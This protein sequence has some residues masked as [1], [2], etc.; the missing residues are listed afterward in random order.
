MSEPTSK[1]DKK[2]SAAE[3]EVSQDAAEPVNKNKRHRKE[4]RECL[5]SA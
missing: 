4:K 1:K 3:A 2:R 5:F